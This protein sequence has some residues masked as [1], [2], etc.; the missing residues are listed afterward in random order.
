MISVE[1]A[2]ES[3]KGRIINVAVVMNSHI[4]QALQDNITNL[5]DGLHL[6]VFIRSILD[7]ELSENGN[8]FSRQ[9]EKEIA[10]EIKR[11]YEKGGWEIKL[12]EVNQEFKGEGIEYSLIFSLP[13]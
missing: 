5:N 11:E 6:T 7:K 4:D 13:K 9:N 3:V 2:K 1:K 10:E 12:A 8:T